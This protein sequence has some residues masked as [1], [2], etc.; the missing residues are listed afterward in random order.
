M[1]I[2]LSVL[3]VLYIACG[4]Q[5]TN[6]DLEKSKVLGERLEDTN[7]QING[8]DCL[9]INLHFL[10]IKNE[11]FSAESRYIEVFLEESSFDEVNLQTLFKRISTWYPK[12]AR[13]TITV[14]TNWAQLP[15]P[16]SPNCPGGGTSG[17][18]TPENYN[19]HEATYYR[20]NRELKNEYFR[21]NPVLETSDFK[22][23]ILKD[24]KDRDE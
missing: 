19:Y 15:F 5:S 10:I 9:P 17:S 13:L 4:Q 7:A 8:D 3:I 1:K 14:K 2:L 16:I 22:T 21:Y 24:E 23:V 12:P 20:R 18:K 11:L 6:V